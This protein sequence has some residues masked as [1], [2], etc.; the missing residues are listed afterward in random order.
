LAIFLPEFWGKESVEKPNPPNSPSSHKR[1]VVEE[2]DHHATPHL[3]PSVVRTGSK[4]RVRDA[5]DASNY[6][7][8]ICDLL[9]LFPLLLFF[10]GFI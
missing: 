10:P 5:K 1:E 7:P 8:R 4:E 2:D 3:S 9:L 6:T